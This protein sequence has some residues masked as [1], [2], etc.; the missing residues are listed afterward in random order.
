MYTYRYIIYIY[1]ICKFNELHEC[2]FCL[3]GNLYEE[4]AKMKSRNLVDNCGD[5]QAYS[6]T[7]C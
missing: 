6:P 2:K 7:H 5:I 4:R 1:S 3:S